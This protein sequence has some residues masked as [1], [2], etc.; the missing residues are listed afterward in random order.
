MKDSIDVGVDE[1][2]AAADLV[3]VNLHRKRNEFVEMDTGTYDIPFF[4]AKEVSKPTSASLDIL[5][6]DHLENSAVGLSIF[7]EEAQAALEVV[8]MSS[9]QRT[10][11]KTI[12]T[13]IE[14]L[15]KRFDTVRRPGWGR[16]R[17]AIGLRALA[18]L[19]MGTF[20]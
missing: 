16:D 15:S 18:R 2:L 20:T 10:H 5:L 3:E 12:M 19:M 7:L 17:K 14:A 8:D 4:D 11:V 6:T 13:Y 9:A 1:L